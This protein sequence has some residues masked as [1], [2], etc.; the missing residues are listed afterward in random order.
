MI[1]DEVRGRDLL[2][3]FGTAENLL[4][5]VKEGLPGEWRSMIESEDDGSGEGDVVLYVGDG[6]S[7]TKLG[8][9][10]TKGINKILRKANVRRPAAGKRWWWEWM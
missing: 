4:D 3:G 10:S 6:D 7:R 2:M 1:V 8:D 5:S 9:I